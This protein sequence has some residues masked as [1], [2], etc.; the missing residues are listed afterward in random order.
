MF[1][2][3]RCRCRR[4]VNHLL[5]A[6][7]ESVTTIRAITDNITVKFDGA[8]LPAILNSVETE[9]NGQKLVLEVSVRAHSIA[10]FY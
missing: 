4:L 2:G 9:N 6:L 7:E 10:S 5:Q 8:K 1:A 3:H